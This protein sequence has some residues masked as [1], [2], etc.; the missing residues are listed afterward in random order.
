[1]TS[2][3]NDN[4]TV[5]PQGSST[6]ELVQLLAQALL[7]VT[8]RNNASASSSSAPAA[9]PAADPAAILAP[10][11][12]DVVEDD[13][14]PEQFPTYA[15]DPQM[16]PRPTEVEYFPSKTERQLFPEVVQ[17]N[18]HEWF[19]FQLPDE[20]RLEQI[21]VF[22]KNATQRYSAPPLSSQ[23][24]C[25]RNCREIDGHLVKLQQRAAHLT[26]PIDA[27]VHQGLTIRDPDDEL[28]EAVLSFAQLMRTHLSD[29]AGTI[30][31][32]RIQLVNKDKQVP[33]VDNTESLITP[34]QFQEQ[35]KT[36]R[37]LDKALNGDDKP[38]GKGRPRQQQ[39]QQASSAY[40]SQQSRYQ[41]QRSRKPFN[42]RRH[43]FDG[44]DARSPSRYSESRDQGNG[45]AQPEPQTK[46][47]AVG[48]R[49]QRF[50]DAWRT[51]SASQDILDIVQ[52]GFKIPFSKKPPVAPPPRVD[53]VL[54]E[55]DM[56]MLDNEVEG[57][58]R[59]GNRIR[60][61]KPFVL[62]LL[63][64]SNCFVTASVRLSWKPT[65]TTKSNLIWASENLCSE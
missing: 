38:K 46:G 37:T 57:V 2:Q 53:P 21:R 61:H 49:L 20:D 28:M 59:I 17:D 62:H 4:T 3:T 45:R 24:R 30:N 50:A 14:Y 65:W 7:E 9:D 12:T 32:L 43:D 64:Y 33:H 25:S 44:D 8:N 56:R 41:Q 10:S 58:D 55:E 27:L 35:A 16:R 42:N 51:I 34:Q 48:G 23:L 60:F 26:R 63:H 22:P 15:H 6:Q 54:S 11:A 52:E 18:S 29:M 39:Y 19:R 31:A 36:A 40:N 5:T 1:M 13:I 47:P